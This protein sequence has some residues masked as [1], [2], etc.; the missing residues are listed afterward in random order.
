[1]GRSTLDNSKVIQVIITDADGDPAGITVDT[2]GL[3]TDVGQDEIVAAIEAID[4][5]T[6]V[7]AALETTQE[8]VLDTLQTP[9]TG[10][11]PRT[12]AFTGGDSVVTGVKVTGSSPFTAGAADTDESWALVG[13]AL[14]FS[15]AC[16]LT[17]EGGSQDLELD[18]PSAGVLILDQSDLP[19]TVTAVNTA[20]TVGWSA[21]TC[22]GKIYCAKGV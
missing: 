12:V 9:A 5:P 1:M 11:P 8:Q 7:G 6:P 17:I 16:T 10:I 18:I 15:A 3:A 21:G 19:Y 4:I 2:T 20:L 13:L 22:K 14:S